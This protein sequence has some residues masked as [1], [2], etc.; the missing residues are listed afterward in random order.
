MKLT[1]SRR[2]LAWFLTIAM[3]FG[4]L[5]GMPGGVLMAKADDQLLLHYE[6][7]DDSGSTTIS[8]SS[9]R[10]NNGKLQGSGGVLRDG[11]VTLPGG[12]SNSNAAYVEIP[13]G[14]FDKQDTLT[15]SAWVKNET[16]KGNYAAMFFGTEKSTKGFPAQYWLFNPCN[17][18]G[19]YKSVFTNSYDEAAPWGTEY[20]I[21]PTNASNGVEGPVT[22]DNWA[23]YTTV[24]SGSAITG[25]YNGQKYGPVELSRT[26]SDFGDNLYAYIGKSSYS[27]IFFKGSVGDVKVYT[28][29]L[30]QEEVRDEYA[31]LSDAQ[32][33]S[34][35]GMEISS[36]LPQSG[37]S[38]AT[39][40]TW[41]ADKN[42][43]VA[44]DGT[45]T[46]PDENTEVTLTATF[47]K[48]ES[49]TS[50][51]F[52][53]TILSGSLQSMLERA[54]NELYIGSNYVMKNLTLPK[55]L[56]SLEGST[57]EWTTSDSSVIA[58]DGTVK[59]PDSGNKEVILTATVKADGASEAVKKFPLVVLEKTDGYLLS[60]TNP[61]QD[62][63][64]VESSLHLAYSK[65]GDEF[66]A[67]NSNSGICFT[68]NK[69]SD[70]GIKSPYLFRKADGTYAF[71]ATNMDKHSYVY[72]FE[73]K[74]LINFTGE[75]RLELNTSLSVMEPECFYDSGSKNYIITWTDGEKWYRN[76][77]ADLKTAG[78]P[79]EIS[80]TP[81]KKT[82]AV[83][84]KNAMTGNVLEVTKQE[85]DK[86]VNK[87]AVVTNTEIEFTVTKVETGKNID[88]K[89]PET[90]KA[91]YS[92]GSVSEVPIS[93][94]LSEVD[95][96]TPGT[97]T[98]TGTVGYTDYPNPFI[99]SKADPWI[100]K[101]SD[102]Y[103]YFTASYPQYGSG[104]SKGYSKVTLRRS[105]T[106]LGLRNAEEVAIWNANKT[107]GVYR[108]IWAPEIHEIDGKWYVFYTGSV[109]S[110]DVWSIRPHVLVCADGADP[111]EPASWSVKKMQ[112][113]DGGSFQFNAF[114][115]DMT[116]FES[117]GQHYVIWADK[118]NENS[119]LFLASI[120]PSEPWKLTSEPMVLTTPEYAWEN[121]RYRVNEGP[122]VLKKNGKIFVCF[123]A[124]GTG[125]EYCIGLMTAEEGA[126]L[127][128]AESW[129]KTPYPLLTSA[130]V[131]GE[132][133]PG[134]NSFTVDAWGNDV[135]VYHA[136]TEECNNDECE[137]GKEDPLYDPCRHARMKTVHWAEDGTPILKMTEEEAV[138]A[139]N[140]TVSVQVT[141]GEKGLEEILP[142]AKYEFKD[143]VKDSSGNGHDGTIVGTGV[144][145]ADGVLTLSGATA[146][147]TNYV[148]L[149]GEIFEGKDNLTISFWLKN[150]MGKGN[151]AAL[152]FGT[153]KNSSELS[154]YYWLFNPSNLKG[155]MKT[156]ITDG[157]NEAMPHQTERGTSPTVSNRGVAGP[158]TTGMEGEW[159]YYTTVLTENSITGYMN[160]ES[161]G[162]VALTEK[163]VSDF[164]TKLLA[165]IGKSTYPD[166]VYKG[167]FRNITI[168]DKS[169]QEGEVKALFKE[170]L[171]DESAVALAKSACEI[172][173]IGSGG[174]VKTSLTLPTRNKDYGVDIAWK[175]SRPEVISNTGE[176]ALIVEAMTKLTLTATFTKGD[177]K[178]EKIFEV[179]VMPKAETEY[180]LTVDAKDTGAD[181]N[182]DL[183]GI[184]FEDINN[185]ADGGLNP[186]MVKNDS[187]ENYRYDAGKR[188]NDYKNQWTSSVPSSFTI[189]S[190]DGMNENNKNYAV[191]E[192]DQILTNNGYT[193]IADKEQKKPSMPVKNGVEMNFSVFTKADASYKGRLKVRVVDA[194]G[195]P[196]TEEITVKPDVSGKWEKVTGTL[197]GN[198]NALG[199][200]EL[201]VTGSEGGTLNLDMVSLLPTDTYGY[202][203][204]NYGYGAG[205]RKDLVQKLIDLSPKFVRFP[206]GCIIEGAYEWD[207]YYDWENTVGPLEQRKQI[208]NMW[209]NDVSFGYMQSYGFGY[210]EILQLCEDMGAEPYPIL[211]AGILC[212]A[213]SDN[214][215]AAEGAQ[216]DAFVKD[217]TDLLDY[218]WGDAKTNEMAA[219]RAQN[220]HEEPFNLKYVGIGNENWNDMYYKNFDYMYEKVMEYK[221]ANYP[222]HELTVIAA[223]GVAADEAAE[224]PLKTGTPWRAGQ[225]V[226]A[227]NWLDQN[228]TG[229]QILV[230]EHYY[231]GTDFS[232]YRDDRYDYFKREEDGG[233]PVFLGEY[234]TNVGVTHNG[235][236]SALADAVYMTGVE[237]N[238]D[239]VK[240]VSYAPLFNKMGNTNWNTNL[241][242]FDE[243]N[244]VGSINYYVQQMFSKYHGTKLI[245]ANLEKNGERYGENDGSPV[246]GTWTTKGYIESVKVTREDGLVLLDETFDETSETKDLWESFPGSDGGF[247]IADGKLKLANNASG[248]N[249][250]WLPGVVDNP[251]WHDYKIEAVVV[252]ESG[253]E[254]FLVGAGAKG[255]AE[256][257]WYNM[258]GWGDTR[259]LIERIRPGLGIKTILGNDHDWATS[260]YFD[261]PSHKKVP[262]G[263]EM[264]VTFNFGV[265]DKLEAGFTSDSVKDY[266]HNYSMNLRPYQSDIYN[267][268]TK[269]DN[270]V[271]IRLVNTQKNAKELTLNL[272]NIIPLE[273]AAEVYCIKGS[274]LNAYNTVDNEAIKTEK[275]NAEITGNKLKYEVPGYSVNTI[276][277]KTGNEGPSGQEKPLKKISLNQSELELS[278]GDNYQLTVSYDP[279]DTTDSK[280]VSWSSLDEGVATV[281]NGMV[282]AVA[283]GSTT[284][285][286]SCGALSAACKVTVKN[287]EDTNRPLVGITLNE[288]KISMKEGET[289]TLT[290]SYNPENTT[291]SKETTWNTS[292]PEVVTVLNGTLEAVKEGTA[293]ITAVCGSFT[294][295][296]EVT[297]KAPEAGEI[298]L[299]SIS[300]N[301]TKLEMEKDDSFQLI[302]SY[303]P[304]NTTAS[305]T[306]TWTTSDPAVATVTEGL[307]T[308][309]GK[310]TAKIT[311]VCQNASAVCEVTVLETPKEDEIKV[312]DDLYA[313]TNIQTSLSEVD[314]S[315]YAGW[316]W[317]DGSEELNI[318]AA[319]EKRQMFPASYQKGEG[320][321]SV[322]KEIPVS[323]SKV[324]GVEITGGSIVSAGADLTLTAIPK[325]LG[326]IIGQS[327][328]K[329]S[330]SSSGNLVELT[331]KQNGVA[332]VKAKGGKGKAVV[333]AELTLL[334]QNGKDTIS[335]TKKKYGVFKASVNVIVTD[336]LPAADIQIGL[337]E[338]TKTGTEVT[339]KN[340]IISLPYNKMDSKANAEYKKGFN[341]I[342]VKA[343]SIKDASGATVEGVS[344]KW[345]SSDTSV[346][347]IS[348]PDANG[349]AV[350]TLKGSGK[351][352][353]TAE[354]QD[355]GKRRSSILLSVEDY[356]PHLLDQ[357]LNLDLNQ[358]KG[359]DLVVYPA[360][361]TEIEKPVIYEYTDSKNPLSYQE[362]AIFAVSG[363]GIYGNYE[364][365]LKEGAS[366]KPKT[367][368][369]NLAVRT[370]VVK[371][372]TKTAYDIPIK[373]SVTETVPAIK[374]KQTEKVN[375][376]YADSEGKL[377]VSSKNAEIQ[378]VEWVSSKSA[379][380]GGFAVEY[381]EGY[382]AAV[383]RQQDITGENYNQKGSIQTKGTLKIKFK[384]YKD[385]CS[386]E[387]A[388]TILTTVQKP[389]LEANPKLSILYPSFGINKIGVTLFDKKAKT[390][391]DLDDSYSFTLDK[392]N[393]ELELENQDN[394]ADKWYVKLK[395]TKGTTASVRVSNTNWRDFVVITHKIAVSDKP[396]MKLTQ[397]T[398]TLNS[399]AAY[400][401]KETAKTI[402]YIN[403]DSGMK[404]SAVTA[405]GA[406]AEAS[407]LLEKG[408]IV[409]NYNQ[410][411][412]ELEMSLKEGA[413][414]KAKGYSFK[415]TGQVCKE[416]GAA[417]Y[418]LAPVKITVKV[419]DK[420]PVITLKAKGSIDILNR[421]NTSILYTP[422][423]ANLSGTVTDAKLT[424][425]YANLFTAKLLTEGAD[426]GKIEVKAKENALLQA[427]GKYKN[428]VMSVVLDQGFTVSTDAK[429]KL[430]IIPKQSVPKVSQ[431]VSRLTAYASSTGPEYAGEISFSA[432]GTEIESITLTNDYGAFV[433]EQGESGE[434]RIYVADGDHLKAGKTYSLKFAITF[435]GSSENIKPVYKT[436]KV[437]F[438]K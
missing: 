251:D 207:T 208:P 199:R 371:D 369:S 219:M 158:D 116:E 422:K 21:S 27:D 396:V 311:A 423:L 229:D 271:Y 151:Y 365:V 338:S 69:T 138:S 230:D 60:Y 437:S 85:Y 278:K 314:L 320:F 335:G 250:V 254:G 405:E 67:L 11:A 144:T 115:L 364:V 233:L 303:N 57:V 84:P 79:M 231:V 391:I 2:V 34:L 260:D 10:G 374:V 195:Q 420:S 183:V 215:S 141:V 404:I 417:V 350:I 26:V 103:Y 55:T 150:E 436:V 297:V 269:D 363:S 252:K 162:T 435:K 97:Y 93:W 91:S 210:H 129:T 177:A 306:V 16:G 377:E 257:Y 128:K 181:L 419:T 300:L 113:R 264:T 206:G 164:G 154:T 341:Q 298:P 59:R 99:E 83:V 43:I 211:N 304:A 140:K 352:T 12:G 245:Q 203:N 263:E 63:S 186:Q 367:T 1:K 124:A 204:K 81:E 42:G 272:K 149:P 238:S 53:V 18:A 358:T 438:L 152:F 108:F 430:T 345:Y 259:Y 214:M 71:I 45:V 52:K 155:T 131:P 332:V 170:Q 242:W 148:E 241:I 386:V 239:I 182:E 101:G 58:E 373:L 121:V 308:A 329:V 353:I 427:K 17:G 50:R 385:T 96:S 346:A 114:S 265:N 402:P 349:E 82:T 276:C 387:K 273:A 282:T 209:G 313:I 382:D 31:V 226:K 279:I 407:A 175:S 361:N 127:L 310:G 205:L 147:D 19:E 180:S 49:S 117:N 165:Y 267:V 227:W 218:C 281:K 379:G 394:M 403:G 30:T 3:L 262:V 125:S 347:A 173:G 126:D 318:S 72:L 80:H 47:K 223:S 416:E 112:A 354:A 168:Y 172:E 193:P 288:S 14:I 86:V 237:R 380:Q 418:P 23:L 167:S 232:K 88:P 287:S 234:A 390:K 255:A 236:E 415:L 400:A 6:F 348:K 337:S 261:S 301:Q 248:L 316:T 305:K 244:S 274:N 324:E 106:I 190:E 192:G 268:V 312:P 15:I 109:K 434:G 355:D 70:N 240:N 327:D 225:N 317:M 344:L 107:D 392:E 100:T 228:H 76:V 196:L 178:E 5:P 221:N 431:S 37:K 331:E 398:V 299:K 426:A 143:G 156:V 38:G 323:V 184:F 406:N 280:A 290:V 188:V 90:A 362:S 433:Y 292:N 166:P 336:K 200:L 157:T 321:A 291:D 339:L 201:S 24:I 270:Y 425:P 161:C 222:E 370:N 179:Y 414:L 163:K 202:G 294:A 159:V 194:S 73:S 118:T 137:Y 322:E 342:K 309:A 429:K 146:E 421:E 375:L 275:S 277:I 424:G 285:T 356:Q 388:F 62:N 92:D 110:N 4:N 198:S 343:D 94:D 39:E 286:A 77:S 432:S 119:E 296:C 8:D 130:D 266:E 330:W 20:G 395:G 246:I 98:A 253:S 7:N 33:M 145:A 56:E 393:A 307:V 176:L 95:L 74:D 65:T 169:F 135:F 87:L 9:G 220:G 326:E 89:M 315:K 383:I 132:Y 412:G 48:G 328:Y 120:N 366:V 258:G 378:S 284:I 102:G 243:Y 174:L 185:S 224:L 249:A 295:E 235:L 111:M 389:A 28:K 372:G 104:D 384:N 413:A 136:R 256:Y 153:E 368:Y 61:D 408:E 64:Y 409:I 13:Q 359:A 66:S 133:G 381:Q 351:T 189:S 187:F 75:T 340:G 216:R 357:K 247:T 105:R 78:A 139:E 41:K 399:K 397:K 171:S 134:H 32:A 410:L 217:V 319:N 334:D 44:E 428:L 213:R 25:Y 51:Q 401:G 212:Q 411:Q 289:F 293:K 46:L 68:D 40:I 29:Q 22:D 302:V 142:I 283:S 122:S 35:S 376:F 36:N 160:G 54:V 191:L 123:S 197:T 360:Y 333:K 325:L